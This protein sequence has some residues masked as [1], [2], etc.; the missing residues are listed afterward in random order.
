MG[1]FC[2]RQRPEQVSLLAV[3][4]NRVLDD[5]SDRPRVTLGLQFPGALQ[6]PHDLPPLPARLSPQRRLQLTGLGSAVI[7]LTGPRSGA[8][9]QVSDVR[10]AQNR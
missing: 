5:A 3:H 1:E 8:I 9:T 7:R 4:G 10:S 6:H 2:I